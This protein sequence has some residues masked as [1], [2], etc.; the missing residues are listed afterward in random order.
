MGAF[1][2]DSMLYR[3]LIEPK[4]P[5]SFRK[6]MD[7]GKMLVVNLAKGR[8]GDDASSL[9]EGRGQRSE[10]SRVR[11]SVIPFCKLLSRNHQHC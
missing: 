8:I 2:S 5:L 1:F 10:S 3:V 7:D 11:H 6:V 4:E 9:S